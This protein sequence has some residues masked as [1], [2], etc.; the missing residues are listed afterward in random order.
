[1]QGGGRNRRGGG[2]GVEAGVGGV[3]EEA[4]ALGEAYEAHRVREGGRRRLR[5]DDALHN[6]FLLFLLCWR[7]TGRRGRLIV[8]AVELRL[9]EEALLPRKRRQHRLL[10]LPRQ[11]LRSPL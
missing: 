7:T 9:G 6:H 11:L 5:A 1:M 2:A 4:G 10:S 8:V 3:G